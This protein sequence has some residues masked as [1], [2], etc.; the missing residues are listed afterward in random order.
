MI[1]RGLVPPP[2]V[3]PRGFD[4]AMDR[5]R[6]ATASGSGRHRR[7]GVTLMGV[8]FGLMV[9]IGVARRQHVVRVRRR[10]LSGHHGPR[11]FHQQPLR[12]SRD[13][14]PAGRARRVPARPTRR[15]RRVRTE[16]GRS[17]PH[18]S[19]PFPLGYSTR[20]PYR[21][22][23][24]APIHAS[25]AALG[26]HRAQSTDSKTLRRTALP[27]I[28]RW[29]VLYRQRISQV[30]LLTHIDVNDILSHSMSVNVPAPVR[31]SASSLL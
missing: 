25:E 23:P 19:M 18:P 17:C 6:R 15:S 16:G 4:R 7:A 13:D 27:E 30:S 11:V 12:Q 22:I 20:H 21:Y 3:D 24:A 14:Y 1:E 10:R 2:E 31:H 5:Y 26:R 28:C 8:G 29:S 9:L